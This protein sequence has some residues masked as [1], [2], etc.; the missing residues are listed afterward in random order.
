MRS[1]L[2]A[3]GPTALR[4]AVAA[5]LARVLGPHLH[6]RSSPK[7]HMAGAV[8]ELHTRLRELLPAPVEL[9]GVRLM[10]GSTVGPTEAAVLSS[11][12][13]AREWDVQDTASMFT[14]SL[15]WRQHFGV[16]KLRADQFRDFP[17]DAFRG[18]TSTGKLIAV[19]R[20]GDLSEETFNDAARF[21]RWRIY[22]QEIL[23]SKLDFG[24]GVQPAYTLVLDCD[25]IA[26]GHFSKPA[27]LCAKELSRVF[28]DHYPD[29]L[30]QIVVCNPPAIFTLAFTILRP[31][32]PRNLIKIIKVHNGDQASCLKSQGLL[33]QSGP[34][35]KGFGLMSIA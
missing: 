1:M 28:Q 35:R 23:N 27:R 7:A 12:L 8:Q 33:S 10:T 26:S 22:I 3:I 32:L 24:K 29:F 2:A 19:L 34:R 6:P 4:L 14:S 30:D 15:R 5:L 16:A 21:L 17:L 9:W 31:V 25:G 20:L 13:R 18:R 11:F